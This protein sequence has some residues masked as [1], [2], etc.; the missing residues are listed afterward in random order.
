MSR[1][2]DLMRIL[3]ILRPYPPLDI[4]C[5]TSLF[6]EGAICKTAAKRLADHPIVQE[7][8]TRKMLTQTEKQHFYLTEDAILLAK[9]ALKV[10]PELQIPPVA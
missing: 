4:S 1:M 6:L 3:R 7:L 8:E 10:Y 9:G 5:L 2:A